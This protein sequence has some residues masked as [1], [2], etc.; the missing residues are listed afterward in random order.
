[1]CI[2]FVFFSRPYVLFDQAIYLSNQM[3]RLR[4]KM[5]RKRHKRSIICRTHDEKW[6]LISVIVTGALQKKTAT[7]NLAFIFFSHFLHSLVNQMCGFFSIVSMEWSITFIWWTFRLTDQ[8]TDTNRCGKHFPFG[9]HII[10]MH[11]SCALT[12]G[13]N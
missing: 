2:F 6:Q 11:I 3:D 13:K 8:L 10:A 5:N 4:C 12:I 9:N 1:M 7:S